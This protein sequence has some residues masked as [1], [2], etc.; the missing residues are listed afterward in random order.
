MS[1]TADK[2]KVV[3][4]AI[5][6]DLANFLFNYFLNKRKVAKTLLDNGWQNIDDIYGTWNDSQV[7]NT[8]SHYSDIAMET[9]LSRVKPILEEHTGLKLVE[10]YSYARIY[11]KGDILHKHKDRDSCQISCTLNLGGPSWPIFLEPDP[12]IGGMVGD[13]YVAGDSKGKEIILGP[14]DL[15]IYSGCELEHWREEFNSSD[16]TQVFLHY[17]DISSHLGEN[18]RFDQRE[19]L[20]LPSSFKKNS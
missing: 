4:E 15:L 12:N 5:S 1:F 20:G 9:L 19:H 11:K 2:Y 7:P 18:N 14:G 8:Y 16:C 6:L 13:N 17:N 3:R 10:T